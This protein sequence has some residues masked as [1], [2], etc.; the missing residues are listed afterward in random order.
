MSA[1]SDNGVQIIPTGQRALSVIATSVP[2]GVV[3]EVRIGTAG[4]WLGPFAGVGDWPMTI[5]LGDG[6]PDADLNRGVF[7]RTT[8]P[9]GGA[10]GVFAVSFGGPTAIQS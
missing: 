9:L 10:S 6:L 4:D 3:Y 7:V 8:T 5:E 2:V 1:I